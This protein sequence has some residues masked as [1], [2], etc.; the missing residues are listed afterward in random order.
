M[1][2]ILLFTSFILIL[3]SCTKTQ[4]EISMTYEKATAVYGDL[5]AIRSLPLIKVQQT[6]KNPGKIYIGE[7][8]IL[9]GEEGEG[10][11]IFDNSNMTNPIRLSFLQIPFNK[12]FFVKDNVLYAESL[13]DFLKIDISNVYQPQLISRARDVFGTPYKNDKGEALIAFSYEMATDVFELNS[14]EADEIKRQGKM[15]L[16]YLDNVIPTST[17][18]SSFTSTSNGV[19]TLNRIAVEYNHIYVLGGNTLHVL[20]NGGAAIIHQNDIKLDD[21]MET[22]YADNNRL[23]IGSEDAML[24]YNVNNPSRPSKVSE[25][26]HTTAC[27]PVL[28]NGNVAYMTLR[29]VDNAGCNVA[30]ENSLTVVDMSNEHEPESIQTIE[31]ESP[32]GMTMLGWYLVVGEGTNGLAI[33]DASNPSDLVEVARVTGIEAYDVMRHPSNPYI[34]MTTSSAGLEQF[35]IDYNTFQLTP[36]SV[37]NY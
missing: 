4:G 6:L 1:K 8:Y 27:D 7:D 26:S 18:P 15:H 25:F 24:T 5:E 2:N 28:P 22:I 31:M 20:S 17:I 23:Y 14:P 3:M 37:V 19:G 10:I 16:D 34:L 21:G 35:E 12:E 9:V 36:L 13:Y 32:Y 11:H 33:F 30:D 29:S